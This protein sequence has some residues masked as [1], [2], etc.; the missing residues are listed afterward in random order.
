MINKALGH[1][2]QGQTELTG[3]S[4]ADRVSRVPKK[5]K[6]NQFPTNI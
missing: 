5:K 3:V 6:K 4:M 2:K 1:S